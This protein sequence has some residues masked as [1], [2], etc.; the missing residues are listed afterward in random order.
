MKIEKFFTKK[1]EKYAKSV[2]DRIIAE[3]NLPLK[4]KILDKII[5]T[6]LH[7]SSE[8]YL[9]DKSINFNQILNKNLKIRFIKHLCLKSEDFE[10]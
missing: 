1:N 6:S 8:L 2:L 3:Y 7:E 4:D 9:K 5:K 10:L